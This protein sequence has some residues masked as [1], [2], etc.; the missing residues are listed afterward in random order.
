MIGPAMDMIDG[1]RFMLGQG[2]YIITHQAATYLIQQSIRHKWQHHTLDN[3][4]CQS[5]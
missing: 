5:Q 2:R 3:I 1:P 4:A